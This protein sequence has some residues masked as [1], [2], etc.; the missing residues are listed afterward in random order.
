LNNKIY[1]LIIAGVGPA[2]LTA[3]IYAMRAAIKTV[4]AT[5]DSIF[6]R[7]KLSLSL[8]AAHYVETRKGGQACYGVDAGQ[9]NVNR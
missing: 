7:D 1:D 8:A 5:C 9:A 4:C 3:W 6:F 2:G